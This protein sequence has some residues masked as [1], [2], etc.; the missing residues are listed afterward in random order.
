MYFEL[1][2]P[3]VEIRSFS[4]HELMRLTPGQ[5]PSLNSFRRRLKRDSNL[6]GTN[7]FLSK[8]SVCHGGDNTEDVGEEAS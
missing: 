4:F 7:P 8:R 6:V 5:F 3:P 2:T 1:S